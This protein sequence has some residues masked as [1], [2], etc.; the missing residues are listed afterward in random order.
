M[1]SWTLAISVW[2]GTPMRVRVST[3]IGF[4]AEV[5][6]G[7]DVVKLCTFVDAGGGEVDRDFAAAA[8]G[9]DEGDGGA[10]CR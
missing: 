8:G 5:F 3:G 6:V 2:W 4:G 9:A 7:P 10:D 1:K